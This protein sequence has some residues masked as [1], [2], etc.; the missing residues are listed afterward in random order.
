VYDPTT[1]ALLVR[2]SEG[3]RRFDG[4]LQELVAPPSVDLVRFNPG[5]GRLISFGATST[6]EL[7]DGAWQPSQIPVRPEDSQ[8]RYWPDRG[9]WIAFMTNGLVK[10]L[11]NN[12]WID[13]PNVANR[14]FKIGTSVGYHPALHTFVLHGGFSS[15]TS[16]NGPPISTIAN[17]TFRY[18][19]ALPT[20]A[21]PA[22][23]DE[24]CSG[25]QD[26]DGD[27][28]LGCA[29]PDCMGYCTPFCPPE[30]SCVSVPHCG[31]GECNRPEEDSLRCE[32]DCLVDLVGVC[33][34]STCEPGEQLINCV[35]DCSVCGDLLCTG[36]ETL[37]SC[38]LDCLIN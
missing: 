27:L 29:D 10:E 5:T 1:D 11:R 26:L 28:L 9:T 35:Q 18:Q 30:T 37:A 36:T 16:P 17:D 3:L 22:Q 38:A 25:V 31:D 12:Q 6:E 32:Q 24:D 33:G 14:F 19:F 34:N 23:I 7:V 2:T 20:D 15:V 4:Q 13:L 8:V 21:V